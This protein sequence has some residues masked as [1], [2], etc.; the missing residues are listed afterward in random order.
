MARRHAVEERAIVGDD[1]DRAAVRDEVLLEPGDGVEIEVV[2][3]LVE[4][5][6][7]GLLR[8]HD[9]EMKT[10]S[11]ASGK[12]ATWRGMCSAGKPSFSAMISTLRSSSSPRDR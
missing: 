2:R 11:L 12:L 1:E 5:E 8:Q 4:Q 7:I 10:A 6:Q 3:R 9:A